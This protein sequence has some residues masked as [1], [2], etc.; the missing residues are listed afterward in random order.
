MLF[1]SE[2]MGR[3]LL[4]GTVVVQ[5]DSRSFDCVVARFANDNFAQ[6]DK[7]FLDESALGAV[8]G[9]D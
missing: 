8:V 6:D 4:A 3:E 1:G 2:T 5:A 9:G 7:A